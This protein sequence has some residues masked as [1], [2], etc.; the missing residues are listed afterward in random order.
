[1]VGFEWWLLRHRVPDSGPLLWCQ[2]SRQRACVD[3]T[4]PQE[5]LGLSR[6]E[7]ARVRDDALEGSAS[8]GEHRAYELF[9]TVEGAM[10]LDRVMPR[11]IRVEQRVLERLP[12]E[13]RP[14]FIKCIRLMV[15]RP[16]DAFPIPAEL[17][18][19]Q[20]NLT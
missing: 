7:A 4:L 15:E 6:I 8:T 2:V 10:L 9:L 16:S 1:M 14:L 13:Y 20:S 3:A 12:I 18:P 11:D 19:H 5:L 17:R